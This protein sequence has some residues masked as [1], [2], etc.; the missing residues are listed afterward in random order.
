MV[1][2]SIMATT[3]FLIFFHL[4]IIYYTLYSALKEFILSKLRSKSKA[5]KYSS[6]DMVDIFHGRRNRLKRKKRKNLK[7]NSL[8]ERM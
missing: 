2:Y 4:S 7:K 3:F 8:K 1:G 5:Q 6:S